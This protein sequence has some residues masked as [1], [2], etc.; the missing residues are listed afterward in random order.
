MDGTFSTALKLFSQL[1]VIRAP[2]GDTT[3]ACA[4]AF[5]KGKSQCM[6]EEVFN[7]LN[8][9]CE[10]LGFNLDPVTVNLDF[11]LAVIKAIKSV[12]GEHVHIQ[13]CF[14]SPHS[15]HLDE[16]PKPWF[17]NKLQRGQGYET[18]LWHDRCSCISPNLFARKN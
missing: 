15:K 2:L 5:L 7:A 16:N 10:E 17:S 12:F 18:L 14:L 3:V 11:E 1:Y 4:Y 9:K 8:N 6:Y 13:G